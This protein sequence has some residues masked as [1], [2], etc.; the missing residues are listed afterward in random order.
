MTSL[1]VNNYL[2]VLNI[3]YELFKGSEHA[4]LDDVE[5]VAIDLSYRIHFMQNPKYM[6][7]QFFVL[8]V[9]EDN[10][11]M[12]DFVKKVLKLKFENGRAFYEFTRTEED[13]L[14]YREVVRMHKVITFYIN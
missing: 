9:D 1:L 3:S 14:Y 5:I 4:C 2:Q 12:S 11:Q 10:V 8:K 6:T 13:L 7:G